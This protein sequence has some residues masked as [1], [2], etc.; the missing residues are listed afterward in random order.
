MTQQQKPEVGIGVTGSIGSDRYPYTVVEIVNARTIVIQQDS[1]KR[2]DKNG[3]SEQQ[4]YEYSRN[5]DAERITLTLRSGDRWKKKG[6]PLHQ[7]YCF[8]IGDRRAY[9]DPSF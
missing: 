5:P 6:D 1:F 7:G 8:F 4:E 3:M 2:T 9:Q